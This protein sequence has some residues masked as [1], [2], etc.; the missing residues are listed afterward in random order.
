MIRQEHAIGCSDPDKECCWCIPVDTPAPEEKIFHVEI[1][2]ELTTGGGALFLERCALKFAASWDL[3]FLSSF[4]PGDDDHAI[5]YTY[6]QE[7]TFE[8][9]DSSTFD[10]TMT[11]SLKRRRP[12]PNPNLDCLDCQIELFD[13]FL[14]AT[15]W[16]YDVE[17][18]AWKT[19]PSD[20]PQCNPLIATNCV[21]PS[22]M[23]PC[24]L[25]VT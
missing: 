9:S 12:Y 11:L 13:D 21:N 10:A 2:C 3:S 7:Q 8:L 1:N 19:T 16:F 4:D 14:D 24:T 25:Q 22:P 18:R 6:R 17:D 5:V 23:T 15:S 20:A